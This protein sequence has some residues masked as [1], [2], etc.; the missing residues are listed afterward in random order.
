MWALGTYVPT[1]LH[2]CGLTKD[3]TTT[4]KRTE[5]G[6]DLGGHGRPTIPV[7][8]APE[9]CG[10]SGSG[11]RESAGPLRATR[12]GFFRISR[13]DNTSARRPAAL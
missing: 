13:V 7:K 1:R 3:G 10:A 8:M 2:V 9:Q 11:A 12:N 5:L 6:V 4:R